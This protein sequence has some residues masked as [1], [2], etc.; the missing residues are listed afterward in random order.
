MSQNISTEHSRKLNSA[1]LYFSTIEDVE[2]VVTNESDDLNKADI[3][4]TIGDKTL[5]I[6]LYEDEKL[7]YINKTIINLSKNYD[8]MCLMF[9][10]SN[11]RAEIEKSIP[12]SCGMLCYSNSFGNG[13]V[14]QLFKDWKNIK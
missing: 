5:G 13:M 14:Y 9:F 3:V 7:E 1:W 8:Y 11:L 12:E 2:N 10:D 6:I 4:A